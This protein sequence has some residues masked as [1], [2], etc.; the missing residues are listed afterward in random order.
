MKLFGL[1]ALTA[2][3]LVG[4]PLRAED[5]REVMIRSLEREGKVNYEGVQTTVVQEG[6]EKRRTRQVVKRRGL[7]QL[8]IEYL[9]PPRLRGELVVDDGVHC[10]HYIPALSLV[11]EGPSRLEHARQRHQER[12]KAL[13]TGKLPVTLVGEERLLDRKVTVVTITPRDPDRPVRTFWLDHDTGVALKV[14][15]HRRDGRTSV[16]TFEQF[17]SNPILGE[18]EFHL[19]TPV[20]ATVVPA[21]MGRPIPPG[22]ATALARRL[23]GGLPTPALLP[24]GYTLT[25]AH[26]LHYRKRPVIALRYTRGHD[27]LSLFVSGSNGEPFAAPI[28]PRL[29]VVQRPMGGMLVTLV[30]SLPPARLQQVLDSV[31]QEEA[32]GSR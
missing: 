9:L 22:R 15:E 26:L 27:D 10:R 12:L 16:T 11:E 21:S 19:E 6:G 13:R 3:L 7:R 1:A 32:P 28:K 8:R 24:A 30:G 20:G 29:N 14:E 25:S 18:S 5:G 23:W 2:L 31:R 17:R 4:A